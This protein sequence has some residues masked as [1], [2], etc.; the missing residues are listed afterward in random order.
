RFDLVPERIQPE[1]RLPRVAAGL[2]HD[3]PLLAQQALFFGARFQQATVGH[4]QQRLGVVGLEELLARQQIAIEAAALRERE[5]SAHHG[6]N[7]ARRA[8]GLHAHGAGLFIDFDAARRRLLFFFGLRE[9]FKRLRI[10]FRP[11]LLLLFARRLVA[12]QR[13]AQRGLA[14]DRL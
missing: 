1:P 10:R 12:R 6:R 13:A 5:Q 3:S 11:G 7:W 8:T 14:G 4:E 2:V 9:F